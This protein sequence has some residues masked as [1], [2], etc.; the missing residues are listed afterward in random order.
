[1]PTGKQAKKKPAKFS[2]RK[3]FKTVRFCFDWKKDDIKYE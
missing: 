2:L 1:M 3:F